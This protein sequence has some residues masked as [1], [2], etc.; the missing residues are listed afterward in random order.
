[1][2]IANPCNESGEDLPPYTRPP[3]PP[4]APTNVFEP[5]GSRLEFDFALYHFVDVQTSAPMIDKALEHW[6]AIVMAYG[7]E[8]PWKNHKELYANIDAI[9]QGDL[10]WKV[11]KI[12]YQGPRP[13]HPPKWMDQ[14]YEL[15]TR[16]ARQVL[17]HQLE[18]TQFK[19]SINLTPYKQFDG[20]DQRIWSNLM[21][22]DW[23]WDQAV[24]RRNSHT[25]MLISLI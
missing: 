8:A 23:A 13:P 10:P 14:T 18:T 24:R 11:Y 15:C 20:N 16:N 7:G 6:A 5:F 9:Q 17:H 2:K 4:A 21:S 12:R 22:A 1:M 3:I 19:D 25:L